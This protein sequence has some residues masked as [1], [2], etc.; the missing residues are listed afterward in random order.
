MAEAILA[1][2]LHQR[3]VDAEVMSAGFLGGGQQMDPDALAAVAHEGPQMK[4]HVS[5]PIRPLLIQGADLVLGMEREHVRGVVVKSPD[6]WE[7]T[8]TLKELVRRGDAVGPWLPGETLAE[9]LARAGRNRGREDLLG[10]ST[11]DDIADP[12]G[13]PASAIDQT[14]DVLRGLCSRLVDLL[15]PRT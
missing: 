12:M 11:E 10:S 5:M 4:D 13:L 3:G 14:A 9:W 2:L 7:K 8:F 6:A 15:A 1:G